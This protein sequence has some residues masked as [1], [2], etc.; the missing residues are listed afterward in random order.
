MTVN[1][2][3]KG[4]FKK[5]TRYLEQLQK[6]RQFQNLAKF[7]QRGVDALSRATPEDTGVT[8]DSWY[9]EITQTK[10]SI[11]I[12]WYNKNTVRGTSVV[13][14][15]QYGHATGSGGYVKGRDLVNPAIGP[16]FDKISDDV[17]KEVTKA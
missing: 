8:A 17:W 5:T 2:N 4:E 16:V 6:R 12:A 13:I 15:L 1:F 11:T 14:M 7:G 10:D 9:Y 3:F